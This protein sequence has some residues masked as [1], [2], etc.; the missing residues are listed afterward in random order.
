M[1]NQEQ[2]MAIAQE[3]VTILEQGFY[4]NHK[5]ELVSIRDDL[6]AAKTK[7]ILYLSDKFNGVFR[8][9]DRIVTSPI[10]TSFEVTNE[11][12]L[13]AASRLVNQG[14]MNQVSTQMRMIFWKIFVQHIPICAWFDLYPEIPE[15]NFWLKAKTRFNGLE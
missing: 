1:A 15:I 11:N 8:E 13:H 10:N 5:G 2:L 14:F 6:L 4:Q 9:R 7:S 3:T 12:T